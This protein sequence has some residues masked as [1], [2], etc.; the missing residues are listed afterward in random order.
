MLDLIDHRGLICG[1]RMRT[2]GELKAACARIP[3]SAKAVLLGADAHMRIETAGA[4]L[5]GIVGDLHHEFAGTSDQLDVLRLYLDSRC[6]ISTRR[7]PLVAVDKLR[8]ALG[9]G[10]KLDRPIGLVTQLLHQ[11]TDTLGELILG[12]MGNVDDVEDA[13]LDDRRDYPSEELGRIRRV[14]ARLRRHMVPQQHALSAF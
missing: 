4:G 6:L 1:Y 2:A 12:M 13:I 8:Q 5:T 10:L 14:A 7:R 9:E 11:L 3:A